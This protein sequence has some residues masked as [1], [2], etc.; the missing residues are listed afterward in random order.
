[1]RARRQPLLGALAGLVAGVAITAGLAVAG[2]FPSD[3]VITGPE[4]Q[5]ALVRAW[6]RSRTGTYAMEGQFVREKDGVGVLRSA[7]FEAQRP[8]ERIRRQTGAIEGVI[9]GR[10]VSCSTK[11]EGRQV[12][13]AG[14]GFVDFQA[15]VADEV[16]R[17]ASY[18]SAEVPLYRVARQGECFL[19]Q[20]HVA[21]PDAPYGRTARMCFDGDT[22]AMRYLRVE[23]DGVV[24]TFEAARIRGVSD[25]DFDLAPDEAFRAT[26]T[27]ESLPPAS[28]GG[29]GDPGGGGGG[30]GGAGGAATAALSADELFAQCHDNGNRDVHQAMWDQGI[31]ANDPRWL[32]EGPD[33]I[34]ALR[35][36]LFY[37]EQGAIPYAAP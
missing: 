8:P 9:D 6:E 33:G 36:M 28:E 7:V 37:L 24:D 10:A 23:Q 15:E 20:L 13:S 27:K 31:S 22:G 3:A 17:M 30:A 34:C 12:C 18:V 35:G 14:G 1:V 2:A 19:L 21:Y 25:A 32:A 11:P 29:S 26:V 4:A 16:A 5:E